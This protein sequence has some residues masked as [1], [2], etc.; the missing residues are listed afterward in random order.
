MGINIFAITVILPLPWLLYGLVYGQM[1]IIVNSTGL[2]CSVSLLLILMIL[3]FLIILMFR[4]KLSRGLGVTLI[5]FYI[6]F[7]ALSITL[8][9]QIIVCPV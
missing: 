9:Y 3:A 7:I 1:S 6:F 8:E 5:V 2:V 4:R